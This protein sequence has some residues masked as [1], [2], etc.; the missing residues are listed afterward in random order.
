MLPL[1]RT[2]VVDSGHFMGWPSMYLRVPDAHGFVF[3]QAFQCVGLGLG[4]A[5]GAALARPDRLTV[6]AVGDGG[7]L[8]ALPELETLG[9][10]STPTRFFAWRT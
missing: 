10:A 3:P 8:M 9:H 7:A 6:A 1:E 5:I 2:V 4:N